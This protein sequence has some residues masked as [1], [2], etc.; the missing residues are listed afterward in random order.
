MAHFVGLEFRNKVLGKINHRT[1]STHS[2]VVNPS[3]PPQ[4]PPLH[5][6]DPMANERA[7]EAIKQI[8]LRQ[9]FLTIV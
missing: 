8:I 2:L 6:N 5:P 1:M 4:S 9:Q 3:P 7:E